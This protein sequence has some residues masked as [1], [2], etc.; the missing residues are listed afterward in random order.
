MVTPGY[1]AAMR[2][3]IV[4]GRDITDSDNAT[5]PGVVIINEQAARQYWPGEDPL[6]KRVSFDDDTTNPKT[7]LTI[8]GIAKDAKQDSWTD[9]ATPEAYLAAFQNHDYLGDSG[10]EASK[11]MDYIT[12]VVRTAGDPAAVA[13]AIKEAAWSFDRNLA[14]SQVVTMDGVVSEANAQPRFEMLL[15]TI[16]AA[17]ALVLAAVGIYGVISYSASRRTHEIGV[18]MSLGATRQDVLLLVVRQ[19]VWLALAGSIAGLAGALL[20]SRLMAGLLYGVQ[21]TDPLTFAGVA[22]GLGVVATLAC[23][24]P[25]RRAMHIDP[26]AALRYE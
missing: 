26:M 25:A 7:W 12:L 14:I 17:V 18:R 2:L 13:S 21:P 1:F 23:Y 6:G 19:G 20:L 22:V 10:T 11:H 8:I 24:I 16:F 15:L 3:P 9:K 5:A 4:R